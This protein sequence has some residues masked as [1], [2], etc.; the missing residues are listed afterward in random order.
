MPHTP[1]AVDHS[2]LS[3]SDMFDHFVSIEFAV[4]FFY[5]NFVLFFYSFCA[6]GQALDLDLRVPHATLAKQY[7][8]DQ[9][10]VLDSSGRQSLINGMLYIYCRLRPVDRDAYS[11]GQVAL[12][13]VQWECVSLFNSCTTCL[14]VSGACVSFLSIKLVILCRFHCSHF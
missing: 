1:N 11:F 5:H 13:M 14:L 9:I 4:N 7:H 2:S 3:C 12:G 8:L 6:S 10:G